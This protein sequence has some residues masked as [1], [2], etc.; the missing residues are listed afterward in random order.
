MLTLNAI[1]VATCLWLIDGSSWNIQTNTP[2]DLKTRI[3][4]EVKIWKKEDEPPEIIN[5]GVYGFLTSMKLIFKGI[6]VA[7]SYLISLGILLIY[8]I[9]GKVYSGFEYQATVNSCAVITTDLI[10]LMLILVT[11]K[12]GV[13]P[14]FNAFVAVAVRVCIV[15]FSG[16]YWFAGYCLLYLILF[17]YISGLII[18]KYYPSY[19]QFPPNKPI[20]TNIFK[21]P[22]LPLIVLVVMFSG[23]VYYM[24][25]D[26]GK[27]LPI[28]TITLGDKSYPFWALGVAC[29]LLSF[30]IFFYMI[31]LRII[32]RSRDRVRSMHIY[33]LGCESCG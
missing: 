5:G 3:M 8:S 33:Y 24:G 11:K 20:K 14:I 12:E 13:N 10:T 29:A 6:F 7:V 22:E 21:M 4:K 32:Q 25:V 9:I 15:A 19:E 28:S 1:F 16:Q 17:V 23:L 2:A 27:T 31:S 30:S 18:N 26:E